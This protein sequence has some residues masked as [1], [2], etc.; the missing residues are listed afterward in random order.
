MCL[1]PHVCLNPQELA[2]SQ[3]VWVAVETPGRPGTQYVA[4]PDFPHL[5][6]TVSTR[7][8]AGLTAEQ[9]SRYPTCQPGGQGRPVLQPHGQQ[10]STPNRCPHPRICAS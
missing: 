4:H 8:G 6:P 3:P 10:C 7:L 1:N 9:E 5:P 2:H